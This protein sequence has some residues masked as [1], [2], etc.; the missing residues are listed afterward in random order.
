VNNRLLASRLKTLAIA[1]LAIPAVLLGFAIYIFGA[2]GDLCGN[3]VLEE[4][5]SPSREYKAVIFR[6]SCGATTGFSTHVSVLPQTSSIDNSSG[7]V[8]RTDTNHGAAPSSPN[9]GPLVHATWVSNN[10]LQ[11]V[12]HPLAH[13]FTAASNIGAVR[14]THVRQAPGA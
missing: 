13:A 6:R 10:E 2:S 8:L 5:L 11:L 12:Y 4:A 1:L 14:I 7:N 3:E 9:G